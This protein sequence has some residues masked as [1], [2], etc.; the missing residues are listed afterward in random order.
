M[1]S[2]LGRTRRGVLNY[3]ARCR[4][5]GRLG[6]RPRDL[7]LD[8]AS[9]QDPHPRAN[10]LCDK[11][12]A[13]NTERSCHASLLV[14]RPLVL[15]DATE[16]PFPDKAF[17]FVFCS[18][19]LEHMEDPRRLLE[20]LQRIGRR[21]YI[22]TPSKIYEKINGWEFHRWFVSLEGNRLV[23]EA[24][25]GVI[26]DGDLHQWFSSR[27]LRT[28]VWDFVVPRLEELGLLTALIW[29][30]HIAYE[31]VGQAAPEGSTSFEKANLAPNHLVEIIAASLEAQQ[32]T[33]AQCA[34]RVMNRWVR[35]HSDSRISEVLE[36]LICVQC[37]R[38]LQRDGDSWQCVVCH[39]A[40]PI[41]RRVPV[42][43]REAMLRTADASAVV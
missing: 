31:I 41:V 32:L 17:D 19:L 8:L 39:T 35:R 10:I 38:R 24:K 21:G 20:E 7:V 43:L 23:L 13:D 11:F 33:R 16:T 29:E 14:D 28:P 30:G 1:L 34:K 3:F 22:E 9:G 18:H 40:Y 26:F 37:R 2:E 36:S 12:A 6:I 4:H 42:M 25:D 5:A 15:A 27:I